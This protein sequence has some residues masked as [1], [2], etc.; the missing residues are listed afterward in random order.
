M[1]NNIDGETPAP[2]PVKVIDLHDGILSQAQKTKPEVAGAIV[3]ENEPPDGG[4][5]AWL[6]VVGSFCLFWNTW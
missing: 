3:S 5:H 6:Q 2:A 4:L 1:S